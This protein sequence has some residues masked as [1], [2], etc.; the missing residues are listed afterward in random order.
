MSEMHFEDQ[1]DEFSRPREDAAGFDMTAL[2]IKWGIASSRQQAEYALIGIAIFA[3]VVALSTWW[4]S[5]RGPSASERARAEAGFQ[6][7]ALRIRN[8]SGENQPNTGTL[9]PSMPQ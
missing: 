3:A 4:W 6:E 9:P 8:M 2:L 1:G 7:A 5:H